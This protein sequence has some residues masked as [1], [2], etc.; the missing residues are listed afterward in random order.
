MATYDDLYLRNTTQDQG[1][2]PR[3]GALCSSPDII[4][5]GLDLQKDPKY[6][7]DHFG[8]DVGKPLIAN[9]GNYLYVRSKNL[10]TAASTG[11]VYLYWAQSSLL[12]YPSQWKNQ[13]M[14]TSS[15]QDYVELK[16]VGAGQIGVTADAFRWTPAMPG[17]NFHYCLIG[18]V[19]TAKH[20]NPIDQ[21]EIIQNFAGWVAKN[22]GIGWRNISVVNA[23]SPTLTIESNYDQG[24]EPGLISFTAKCTGCPLEKSWVQFSSAT[25][26]PDGKYVFIEKSKITQDGQIFGVERQVP[27]N[28]KTT[29]V[30]NYW[31]DAP[32]LPD[33]NVEV[34][35]S[36]VPSM[37]ETELYRYAFTLE[38]LGWQNAIHF[39]DYCVGIGREFQRMRQKSSVNRVAGDG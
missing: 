33:W 21:T 26:L 4:P 2:I 34:S 6:F 1:T 28:W 8:E 32:P 18:R 11:R 39:T 9:G 13:K 22:G 38:E 36:Y 15:G 12:L 24:S 37:A 19:S 35:G 27:A 14:L 30:I 20:D 16:D 25:P 3:Q 29:F 31:A 5:W 7:I 17:G 10:G 23:G